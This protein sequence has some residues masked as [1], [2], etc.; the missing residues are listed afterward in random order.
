MCGDRAVL[1]LGPKPASAAKPV[2]PFVAFRPSPPPLS[3]ASVGRFATLPAS[4]QQGAQDDFT[5]FCVAVWL[6]LSALP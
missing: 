6:G 5:P 3:L 4:A 1:P 2:D